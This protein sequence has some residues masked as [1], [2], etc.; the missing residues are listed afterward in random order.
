MKL[1]LTSTGLTHP[2]II[3][4]FKELIGNDLSKVTIGFVKT[5]S[6]TKE[7]LKYVNKSK[8]ELID[9]GVLVS[10]IRILDF[11]N[12][13]DT[14]TMHEYDVLYVCGGNTF[15]LL[16]EIKR[17]NYDVEI[18]KF[19]YQNKLYVGVSAG[20][21]IPTPKIEIANVEPSDPNDVG[22]NDFSALG[23]IDFEISPHS[24]E[25]VPFETVEIYAKT[26][27]RKIYAISNKTAL[28]IEDT[29]IEA[30]G[31]RNYRLFNF[32]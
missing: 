5:A 2:K 32:E 1:L 31:D 16:N 28:K 24:P 17:N 10:N 21:I 13:N 11:A 14:K 18:K 22:L 7:E 29:K 26:N 3:S 15:H 30:V 27:K 4:A 12:R 20:S 19:I 6:R 8:N 23:I 25:L 9:T